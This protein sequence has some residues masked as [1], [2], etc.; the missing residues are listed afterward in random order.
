MWVSGIGVCMEISMGGNV[1][2]LFYQ[3]GDQYVV[4]IVLKKKDVVLDKLV[5]GQEFVYS[6]SCVIFNF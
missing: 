4:E 5:K 2:M 1:E 3:I 6:G